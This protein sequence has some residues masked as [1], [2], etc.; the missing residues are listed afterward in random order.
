MWRKSRFK[1]IENSKS[2]LI[3]LFLHRVIRVRDSLKTWGHIN[4]DKCALCGRVENIE[5]CLL[6]CPRATLVWLLFAPMITTLTDVP[7]L[8][9]SF[10]YSLSLQPLAFDSHTI[11]LLLFFIGSGLLVISLL[12]VTA[13]YPRSALLISLSR[14]LPIGCAVSP[15]GRSSIFGPSGGFSALLTLLV[16]VLC[17]LDFGSAGYTP[18]VLVLL[19]SS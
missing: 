2:D 4:N 1:L 9:F 14:I 7:V 5:H 18:S 12:S 17:F 19:S 11:S 10:V 13:F 16:N 3:W 15:S 6:T 8:P